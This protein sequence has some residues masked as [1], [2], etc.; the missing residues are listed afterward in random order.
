MKR[1]DS[2]ESSSEEEANPKLEFQ[3]KPAKKKAKKAEDAPVE[4]K[5]VEEAPVEEQPVLEPEATEPKPEEEEA[6]LVEA[7]TAALVGLGVGDLVGL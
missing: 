1:A 6:P 4:E 5:P 7:R 2:V 3:V